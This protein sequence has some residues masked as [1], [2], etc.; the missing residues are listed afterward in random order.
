MKGQDEIFSHSDNS[1]ILRTV[2]LELCSK[3]A[4]EY[5]ENVRHFLQDNAGDFTEVIYKVMMT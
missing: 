5:S 1:H 3:A 4:I 2:F